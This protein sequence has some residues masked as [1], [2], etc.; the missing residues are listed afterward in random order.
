M[1]PEILAPTGTWIN[2]PKHTFFEIKALLHY[3]IICMVLASIAVF[4][5]HIKD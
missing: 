3:F 5:T 1:S 4:I 2:G